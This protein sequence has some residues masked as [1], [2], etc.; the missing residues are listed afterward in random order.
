MLSS[1][2]A[3]RSPGFTTATYRHVLD[4]TT[5]AAAEAL[6]RAYEQGRRT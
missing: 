2:S 6:P 5:E 3:A 1:T 4:G